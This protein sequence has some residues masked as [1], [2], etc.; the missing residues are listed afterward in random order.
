MRKYKI[1][2]VT[3]FT[4]CVA[5]LAFVLFG[6]YLFKN[7]KWHDE[8]CTLPNGVTMLVPAGWEKPKSKYPWD[9]TIVY[10]K[11]GIN[12]LRY[13]DYHKRLATVYAGTMCGAENAQ[14][15]YDKYFAEPELIIQQRQQEM[16]AGY[17]RI[18]KWRANFDS[19]EEALLWYEA[20]HTQINGVPVF[21]EKFV[22]RIDDFPYSGMINEFRWEIEFYTPKLAFGLLA[23]CKEVDRERFEPVFETIFNSVTMPAVPNCNN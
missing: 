15:M 6:E 22:V 5:L 12:T 13:T 1:L 2:G 19:R 21:S 9:G 11:F 16:R 18:N 14:I 23:A 20:E 4:A 8:M 17:E 10:T 3:L 7:S